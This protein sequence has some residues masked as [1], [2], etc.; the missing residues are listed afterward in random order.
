MLRILPSVNYFLPGLLLLAGVGGC[1]K[2][3]DEFRPY[4]YDP[5]QTSLVQLLDQVPVT[6]TTTTFAL[7]GLDHDTT[8]T[9]SSGVRI[10]L[11]DPE[12]LFAYPDGQPVATS[13]CQ[14][15]RVVVIEALDRRALVG[16]RMHTAT[17]PDGPLLEIG[18]AVHIQVTC[19]GTPL[20]L[21]SNRTLKVQLPTPGPTDNMSTF[22][23]AI[24]NGVDFLGWQ[25]TNEPAYQA[26]WV[27]GTDLLEGYETYPTS[28]GW[29][30]VGRPL[31]EITSKFCVELPTA[32]TDQTARV[33]VVFKGV[34]AVGTLE[35]DVIQQAFCFQAPKGYPV[36]VVAISKLGEQ[37]WLAH[38]ATEIGTNTT[39]QMEPQKTSEATLLAFLQS[40]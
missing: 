22:S 38:R 26:E 12:A 5:S 13:T 4:V 15:L 40:L 9:T 21:L 8:L 14:N 30:G 39:F 16:R 37:Y 34:L 31:P 27:S 35:Y 11:T 1:R 25:A 10:V 7:Q 23:G 2:D 6:A 24:P 18:G 33:A 28:L 32:M 36:E 3:V 19:E 20:Q 17:Y 29:V